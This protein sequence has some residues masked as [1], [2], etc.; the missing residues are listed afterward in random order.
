MLALSSLVF[1]PL[2]HHPRV[3]R[4]AQERANN[5]QQTPISDGH[6]SNSC[7]VGLGVAL[8]LTATKPIFRGEI[9]RQTGLLRQ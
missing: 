2:P 6:L 1:Q 8:L 9:A 7:F 5:F 3:K 4:I